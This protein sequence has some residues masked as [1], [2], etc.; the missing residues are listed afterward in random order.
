LL[1]WLDTHGRPYVVRG[2]PT[3]EPGP[4]RDHDQRL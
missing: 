3:N 2:N 4:Y 1:D